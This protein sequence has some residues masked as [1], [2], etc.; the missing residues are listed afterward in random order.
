MRGY[1]ERYIV[2]DTESR[3]ERLDAK[4]PTVELTLRLGM[5][6]IVD[7]DGPNRSTVR[8]HG[9]RTDAEF[10]EMVLG[11]PHSAKPIYVF[12]HNMGF[13]SRMVN[14]MGWLG[15]GRYSLLP[16][17]GMPGAFRY[18]SPLFVTESPP[19]IVRLFRGDGQQVILLDTVQWFGVGIRDLGDFIDYPKGKLP[20]EDAPEDDWWTYCQRDVD[21]LH[22]SLQRLWSFMRSERIPD[23]GAT[24]AAQAMHLYRMRY[25]K[26]RIKR[27]ED[28]DV[29][30]LDRHAYYGGLIEALHVGPI[31][32]VVHEIDITSLY[33]Y[34]M[35]N[36]PFPCEVIDS[37]DFSGESGVPPDFAWSD[38][39]AEVWL[40]SGDHP[41][42]V[43]GK[44]ATLWVTGRI[45]TALAGP[46]LVMA[47]ALGVVRRVGRWVR[48]RTDH[49]FGDFVDH[50]WGRR[51]RAR[52][53]GV[54]IPELVCKA[55]LNALHGKFGQRTGDWVP[56]GVRKEEGMYGTGKYLKRG[57]PP[58]PDFRILDGHEWIRSSDEEDP[59]SFVPIA[60]WTAS[61]GRVYMWEMMRLAGVD[62]VHY[63][64][65]DSLL[66]NGVG[67][68]NLQ[69]AGL[70]EDGVMGL[71][72]HERSHEG[73]H[74]Y[75]VGAIDF[76]AKKVRS[77][78]KPGTLEVGPDVW[79]V[80]RWSSF[81]DDIFHG[82]LSSVTIQSLCIS[83]AKTNL[84]REVLASGM[85]R[86]WSVAN[87]DVS[88]ARQ[89]DTPITPRRGRKVAKPRF[90][91]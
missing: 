66:V 46:E 22:R 81:S 38:C 65:T 69:V 1:P 50:W 90:R 14:W 79:P 44:D 4:I 91:E 26:K 24:P 70:V 74:I 71:F 8:Y 54:K 87:W 25:E 15:D 57:G 28:M 35:H 39:T 27:P 11:L 80:E 10:H 45:R 7:D 83:Y 77:G 73:C 32:G 47:H 86:P 56:T 85:T 58:Y 23:F 41:F 84:R 34:L 31:E 42:P 33:P 36:N 40:E 3:E 60:S 43:R 13:D 88:L 63:I 64:A 72:H 12:A 76:P 75:G 51:I 53:R 9:F 52:E 48:Y 78:V 55:V 18:T 29:L 17:P 59:N 6:L 61:Y 37:G 62:N 5:A 21:V 2:F 82:R 89:K 19:F 20:D 16:P 67:L 30:K 68:G 49:L